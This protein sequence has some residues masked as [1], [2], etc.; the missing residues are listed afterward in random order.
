MPNTMKSGAEKLREVAGPDETSL[1]IVAGDRELYLQAI[2]EQ[3]GADDRLL[4][5]RHGRRLLG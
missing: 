5:P 1:E 2:D 3:M 4:H